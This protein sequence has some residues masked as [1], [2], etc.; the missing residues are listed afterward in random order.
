MISRRVLL[1]LL[2]VAAIVP[3]AIVVIVAVGW[4]LGAMHDEAG[5]WAAQRVALALGVVW[6][7]DLVCL[8]VALAINTLE[9]PGR[10]E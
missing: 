2:T 7:I 5:A 8:L 10:G 6:V 4:L 3:V 1:S 9:P